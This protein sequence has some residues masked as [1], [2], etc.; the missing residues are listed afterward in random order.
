MPDE[1]RDIRSKASLIQPGALGGKIHI[2]AAIRVRDDGRDALG[3]ERL[4]LAQLRTEKS[5][6]GV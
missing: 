6:G 1:Q 2:P 5:F 4:P 3:K